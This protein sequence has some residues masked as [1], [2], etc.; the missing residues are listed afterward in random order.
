MATLSVSE[1]LQDTL[2]AFKATV[3]VLSAFGT[4]FSSKTAK[5]NDTITAHIS[6]LPLV[7]SYH[8]TSGYELNQ[9]EGD[10]LIT[11]VAVT[12]DQHKHVPVRVKY[13]TELASKKNLYAEAIKNQAYAL[14]KSVV[15][16]ALSLITDANVTNEKIESEANTSYETLEIVR[17]G[18][19]TQKA[20]P[21]GRFGIVS[22]PFA[23]KVQQDSR[24]ASADY[25]GQLNGAGGYRNFKNIAGFENVWE[26]PDM[27]TNSSNLTAVFG[28]RRLITVATRLPDVQGE[29]AAALGVPPTSS[30]SVA[31]DSE[32]GLS[33]LGISWQKQGTLDVW[34]T[35]ALIYG[36][37]VGANGGA[38]NS[39]TDKAGYKIVTSA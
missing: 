25:F 8:A 36:A 33:L 35:C 26:Y 14:A 16:Y 31:M 32:T 4:D 24:V 11:D 34:M 15:D 27:P 19:N 12:L 7:Q 38:P 39:R 6:G 10:S 5:L 37:T 21:M 23:K 30:F 2:D 18:L 22:T 9:V 17:S 29:L 1:I 20:A 13:L 28:D 3:P